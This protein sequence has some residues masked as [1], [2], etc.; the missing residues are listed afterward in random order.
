[1]SL[2]VP[3]V[4][5]DCSPGGAAL[6]IKNDFNGLLVPCGDVDQLASGLSRFLSD[7]SHAEECGHNAKNICVEFSED[8]IFHQWK[9]FIAL[10]Q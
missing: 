2:G 3:C 6:L 8:K 7:Q 4:S 10:A 5:T 1:M 9:E